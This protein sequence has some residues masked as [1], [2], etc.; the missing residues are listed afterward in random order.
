NPLV[1]DF[2]D[3]VYKTGDLGR[4]LP[5]G[6]IEVLGRLDNQVKIN[7][8]RVELLELELAIIKQAYITGVTV[9]AHR[10]D[11]NLITLIAYYTGVKT[12]PE[13]LRNSLAK[14]LNQEIIPSYFIHLD[15]FPLTVNGKID[16]KSLPL[17]EVVL[18]GDL[19]FE[20]PIGNL[21]NR[22]AL[23]WMEILGLN[24]IGRNISFF[25]VGGHSLRAIQL[26]SR[27]QK[28]FGADLRIVDVFSHPTIRELADWIA[29]CSMKE[30]VPIVPVK[31]QPHYS[32]SSSQRRLWV[33][34]QFEE[35]N[36]AY[37]VQAVCI[38]EGDLDLSSFERSVTALI[39]RH[40]I[41]RTIFKEN[42]EGEIRQFVCPTGE[43]GFTLAHKD[44]R[45]YPDPE[46]QIKAL[47][48]LELIKPFDLAAGPLLRAALFQV[49]DDK[50]IFAYTLHH[51]II[52]A[53]SMN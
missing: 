21:E 47:L 33:L 19:Y 50:W 22:L 14:E 15:E 4:S 28:E 27:I 1:S 38:F 6:N 34:S 45:G 10:T 3:I 37:N 24:K 41:L 23:L 18:M 39:E 29:N 31:E 48:K 52:D 12:N 53:W 20:P 8:I 35:G 16:K 17:P 36:V 43:I 32:L 13:Q 40:E 44:V 30:Y 7:G 51:I 46:E 5:D 2:K 25:S 9:K 42:E 11:D 26:V 49:A